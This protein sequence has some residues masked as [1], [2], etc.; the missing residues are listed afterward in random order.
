MKLF[1]KKTIAA[2]IAFALTACFVSCS[3]MG[4]GSSL[5]MDGE[6]SGEASA[7][8]GYYKNGDV[9]G[10]IG[11]TGTYHRVGYSG[12]GSGEYVPMQGEGI[13]AGLMTASA[14]FDNDHYEDYLLLFKKGDTQSGQ[15][16]QDEKNED[17]KFYSFMGSDNWGVDASKRVTVRVFE[18][19]S[20][21]CGAKISC[22]NADQT[23]AAA[24]TDAAGKAY[25]FPSDTS[26]TVTVTVGNNTYEKDFS[27]TERDLTME[28]SGAAAKEEIIKLMFVIDVTGSM[29]DE[30]QYVVKELENVI[31]RVVY[32]NGNVSIDL[33]FLFY[34]DDGDEEKFVFRDFSRVTEGNKLAVMKQSVSSVQATGGGDYPEALDEA[35]ETAVGANWGDGNSTKIIF[36]IFD[37]PAHSGAENKTRFSGAVKTA[38]E[39]GI[40][41]NPVLCSGADLLCEYLARQSAILTGGHFVYVT[42][43]SGIGG[44]HHDPKIDDAVVE[45]LNDLMVRLI[46]GYYTGV[47][48][49]PV[50]WRSELE[51][52]EN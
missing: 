6:I 51:E 4:G 23:K 14:R 35:L 10:L 1:I 13:D 22:Y 40:R 28:I 47:F 18:Q 41:I 48:A 27:A 39:K 52:Q 33:S 8:E 11:G 31:S 19:G 37:A 17:G 32:A 44:E 20:P 36:H 3:D 49:D 45:R 25:L 26:G 38:C 29:G 5:S 9:A 43:D 2:L 24:V 50:A 12:E 21:V 46:N 7:P 30:L 42:D 34:R 16:E 15:G